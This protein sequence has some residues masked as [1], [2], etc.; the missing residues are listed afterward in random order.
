[1][2]TIKKCRNN[3]LFTIV[4]VVYNDREGLIKTMSSV[5]SQSF[6]NMEYIIIDGGS[7]DGTIDI[8]KG[9]EDKLA[10]WVSEPD[11]GIYDAMNKGIAVARG[12][13]INFMNA[14]DVFYEREVLERVAAQMKA[15]E[16]VV[17]GNLAVEL[18]G[19]IYEGK[20]TP[21]YEHMPLHH[22]LG[23]NHQCTFVRTTL[24]K[25][26]PFD[27]KYALAADYNMIISLYRE[28]ATFQQ[29]D[30]IVSKYD[31]C[32][33]SQNNK[34]HHL[35]ETL[36]IDNPGRHIYNVVLYVFYR[37][38]HLIFITIWR[39]LGKIYPTMNVKRKIHR[40]LIPISE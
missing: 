31:L 13:Y 7:N 30:M 9:C 38:R 5:L 23:F 19:M 26:H 29:L 10:Y 12:E 35:W 16:D 20:A 6:P 33:V 36:L 22:D 28:G 25:T 18:D 3:P 14:R 2:K 34:K 39:I 1:M 4:T 15:G 21:F 8:I 11:K 24:A 27:L 32:G 37:L 40:G 17:F